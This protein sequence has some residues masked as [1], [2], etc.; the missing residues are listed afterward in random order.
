MEKLSIIIIN[1]NST[2][3]LKKL[4]SSLKKIK[5]YIDEVIIVDNNSKEPIKLKEN[6]NIKLIKNKKN[7][8]FAKAVNQAIKKSKNHFL[9][10]LNPD[11]LILDDSMSKIF[12]SIKIDKNIGAIG[13]KIINRDNKPYFTA[14]NKP[15]FLTG[16]F[17]FTNIKKIFP[18]NFFTNQFWIEKENKIKKPITVNSLCGAFQIFRKFDK[19]KNLNLFDENFFLYLEDIDF[20]TMLNSKGYKVVFDPS[21]T[22]KH[23]GGMSNTSKYGTVLKHWYQSRKYFFNK[24][25]TQVESIIL[26]I[27]FSLEELSLFIYHSLKNE[28]TK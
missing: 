22:I 8:G 15:N 9:L 24:H 5:K 10:L 6:P 26:S 11:C 17:E 13:G 21:S 1:Y 27:V 23:I 3:Y 19:N 4:I 2:K 20:G 7:L 12:N 16:L 25:L 14:N 28:P 18:N